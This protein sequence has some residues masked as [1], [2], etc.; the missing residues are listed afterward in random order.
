[1]DVDGES[2]LLSTGLV[3]NVDM[4]PNDGLWHLALVGVSYPSRPT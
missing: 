4:V 2:R 3:R 1:M